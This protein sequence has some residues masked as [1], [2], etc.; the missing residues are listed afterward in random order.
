MTATRQF[1]TNRARGSRL[2]E[3]SEGPSGLSRLLGKAAGVTAL[4]PTR[5]FVGIV[6]RIGRIRAR[7]AFRNFERFQKLLGRQHRA[8]GPTGGVLDLP[9]RADDDGAV[10][11]LTREPPQL[12]LG[13]QRRA[14][15]KHNENG[16]RA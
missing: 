14:G 13:R 12:I 15:G 5:L 3:A 16:G 7:R 11:Q 2:A 4:L 10:S 1:S 9:I 6:L 8:P